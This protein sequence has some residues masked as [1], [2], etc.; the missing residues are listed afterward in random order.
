MT[1]QDANRTIAEYMGGPYIGDAC[2]GHDSANIP[3]DYCKKDYVCSYCFPIDSHY[4]S[5]DNLVPVWEK[6]N[7]PKII[8]LDIRDHNYAKG[9][10]F[11]TYADLSYSIYEDSS[12]S[13]QE[14]A[15]IAT[16]KAIK[17]LK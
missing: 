3:M 16:A 2:T 4:S 5:L 14:A 6:L 11:R 15:C 9:F 1:P 17:E 10:G 13:I 8:E 7:L 12:E